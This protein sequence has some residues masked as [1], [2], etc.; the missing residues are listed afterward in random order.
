MKRSKRLKRVV[1]W[2]C[3]S[4]LAFVLALVIAWATGLIL[5]DSS[6]AA[7]IKEALHYYRTSKHG[8][9][10]LNGV[11]LY[12]TK[13]HESIDALGGAHHTYPTTTSITA[14]EVPCGVQLRWTALQGRSTIWTFCSTAVG[15]VLRVS[16]ERHSF[17]GQ[18]DHTTYTCDDRLL[19]PRKFVHGAVYP[20]RCSTRRG[21]ET[22]DV[23]ILGRATIK[24]GSKFV[25]DVHARTTLSIHGGGTGGTETINWWLNA[26]NSLPLRIT[27]RSRTSRSLFVGRV[28]YSEDFT[29]RLLSLRPRR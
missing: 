9:S 19:L 29:L 12:A 13:G 25:R 23:R 21:S 14:I 16:D 8:S 22:G 4:A 5:H 15:V 28:H 26:A 6:Q 11:Y 7:S 10:A 18:H 17:F 1:I 3:A 24:I 2:L 20:F 27:M